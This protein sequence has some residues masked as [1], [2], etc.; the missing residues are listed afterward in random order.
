MVLMMGGGPGPNMMG[1]G[2]FY[3]DDD[4][5]YGWSEPAIELVV[6]MRL[7]GKIPFEM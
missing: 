1:G 7:P 6:F 3:Y 2:G 4:Y 5:Y